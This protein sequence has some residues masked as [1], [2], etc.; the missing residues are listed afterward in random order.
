MS[1]I[2]S[3]SS[4]VPV[5]ATGYE[6]MSGAEVHDYEASTQTVRVNAKGGIIVNLTPRRHADKTALKLQ[7]AKTGSNKKP[8]TARKILTSL[9]P[10]KIPKD[11]LPSYK[12]LMLMHRKGVGFSSPA[13]RKAQEK[14]TR[15]FLYALYLRLPHNSPVKFEIA[16]CLSPK[17][18]NKELTS[19]M[20]RAN[21]RYGRGNLSLLKSNN[22]SSNI[23]LNTSENHL[24]A[25]RLYHRYLL[26]RILQQQ[27]PFVIA[28][29]R[30]ES[31]APRGKKRPGLLGLSP[32]A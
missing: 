24:A 10:K 32:A 7:A 13:G 18:L 12:W 17:L 6:I 15:E 28:P 1:A 11:L 9:N 16:E 2:K 27:D 29:V 31:T 23:D 22:V 20:L 19:G 26:D 8:P 30:N 25:E 21:R 3:P 5:D 4:D 14:N